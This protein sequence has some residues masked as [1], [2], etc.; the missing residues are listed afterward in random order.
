LCSSAIWVET[1]EEI[2]KQTTATRKPLIRK[3]PFEKISLKEG[4]VEEMKPIGISPTTERL[5]LP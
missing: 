2:T 4:S 5:K 1:D 3:E